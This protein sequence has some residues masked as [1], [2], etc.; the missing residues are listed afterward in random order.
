MGEK[1]M[2]RARHFFDERNVVTRVV[3]TYEVL[4][5][6]I[7]RT[8]TQ[9]VGE[10]PLRRARPQDAARIARLH[11]QGITTGFLPQ[12]G[13]AFLTIL[14]R[15][16]IRWRGAIVLVVGANEPVGFVAGSVNTPR[17]YR[18]FATRWG[19]LALI[20]ALP[21][22]V[23]PWVLRHAWETLR[24]GDDAGV[25]AE[26]LSMAVDPRFRGL[27]LGRRLGAGLLSA[28]NEVAIPQ[29]KVVVG[30]ANHAAISLYESLGFARRRSIE[31]HEGE[32]SLEMVWSAPG[33]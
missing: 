6:R 12:L 31:V 15:S 23:R 14:Y 24:Y 26:L 5:G 20:A 1:A 29:V 22:L 3:E 10:L 21:R 28:M 25:A 11:R 2:T 33:S 30:A 13:T 9:Q 4:L 32:S 19:I 27:G 17:F 7:G 16:L 18:Y 8:W